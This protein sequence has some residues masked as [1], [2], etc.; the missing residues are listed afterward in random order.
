MRVLVTGH[1][2][3]L[4]TL[5]TP[6]LNRRGYDVR[7]LDIGLYRHCS[8]GT[9]VPIPALRR[10]IR[11]VER[12]DFDGIDV[13]IHLAGLSND[14]LGDLDPGATEQINLAATMR[15]GECARGAGVSRLL[16]ASSCSVYG[17]AG[18]EF[19]DEDS[20]LNPQTPYAACK[21]HAEQG[22]SRLAN[23]CRVM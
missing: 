14:P 1:E 2:G 4:G 21:M 7:G 9:R 12:E 8:T 15:V 6:L 11:D 22:L 5:L 20:V 3:Y 13:V 10:D 19:L 18:E 16:F 17:A 23:D